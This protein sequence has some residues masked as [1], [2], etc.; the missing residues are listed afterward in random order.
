M[1]NLRLDRG[2]IHIG[3]AWR[4]HREDRRVALAA[5]GL[6]RPSALLGLLEGGHVEMSGEAGEE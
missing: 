4:L 3:V 2:Q 6:R 1:Q 5:S